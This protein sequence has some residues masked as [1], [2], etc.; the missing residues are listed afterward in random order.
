MDVRRAGSDGRYP[1]RLSVA[2]NHKT[3]YIGTDISLRK[4]DWNQA[5]GI[6]VSHPHKTLI[7]R[8]LQKQKLEAEFVDL[9]LQ[10]T[11]SYRSMS[12]SEV[13][14]RIIIQSGEYEPKIG[15]FED[16]FLKT[17]EKKSTSTRGVYM[18]TLSRIRA[19]CGE[20]IKSLGFSD[21]T[22]GW[23]SDFESYLAKTAPSANS[24]G[25]HL[26]NIR[27]VLNSAIAEDLTTNYPFRRFRIRTQPTAHRSLSAKRLRELFYYD[28]E[29]YQRRHIDMFM[30]SFF[31]IG[32]NMADMCRLQFIEDGRIHYN[33]CKTHRPYSIKVEPEALEIIKKYKGNKWLID[34]LDRYGRH[35]DYTKRC[36]LGLQAIGKLTISGQG[37]KKHIDPEF[38]GIT[39]YWARH[40]WATIASLL[41][42]PKEVIGQ[43][44]GHSDKS[45]TS[46][47][48][49]YDIS[50]VDRAN[51]MVMDYVLY[52]ERTSWY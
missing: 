20:K 7:N 42:I 31:L 37:G 30:L 36:N 39:M 13:K 12:A 32:I 40:S 25:I 3:V 10:M 45:V 6:C 23:L 44:L 48:I 5:K 16:Y 24:R 17:A 15:D 1:I 47:Y 52:E 21:I 38:P 4:E 51:R 22:P 35:Q 41:D 26:R 2:K 49:D 9:N 34:I 27:A 19:Y 29:K 8:R 18:Q 50:K 43:A 14:N 46:I 28:C 33:R 11:D